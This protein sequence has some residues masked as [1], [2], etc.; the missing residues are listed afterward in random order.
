MSD[1]KTLDQ[2]KA[3]LQQA[4]L[5]GDDAQV[6]VLAKAVNQHAADVKKAEAE[7]LRKEAEALAGQREILEQ[8]I[9]AV[10]SK[11][12]K[13]NELL[14]VKAK[15]FSIVIDHQENDKGQLDAN[16]EVKVTG[17]CKLMVPTIKAAR[18]SSGGGGGTGLTVENQT[19]MKRAELIEQFATDEEKG[20]IKEAGDAAEAEGKNRNSREWSAGQ[21]VV[22]RILK[23]NPE[24]LKR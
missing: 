6:L 2:I 4:I 3:E 22:K 5:N 19:G 21:P 13:P 10:I 9:Y 8:K 23:D 12:I 1:V 14:A 15:G 20:K 17:G 16:G 11:A 18:A 7:K 24:L